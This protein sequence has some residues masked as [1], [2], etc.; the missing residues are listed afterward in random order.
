MSIPTD[1]SAPSPIPRQQATGSVLRVQTV[2][3]RNNDPDDA[4]P[5]R[6][7]AI[8]R[9][10]AYTSTTNSRIWTRR[11]GVR[12]P[13]SPA[14]RATS[15][16]RAVEPRDPPKPS[17]KPT[18]TTSLILN[19]LTPIEFS[20]SS[21]RIPVSENSG[22]LPEQLCNFPRPNRPLGRTPQ[23]SKRHNL[24]Q[25]PLLLHIPRCREFR[26]PPSSGHAAAVTGSSHPHLHRSKSE[27]APQFSLPDLPDRR[28]TTLH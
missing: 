21:P 8:G 26:Y 25:W 16:I 12:N 9:S 27:N 18:S 13:R 10:R 17:N 20:K 15:Q 3:C 5:G 24:F 19:A 22:R 6:L 2:P 4:V 28:S 7:A 14:T 23:K 11:F 1:V